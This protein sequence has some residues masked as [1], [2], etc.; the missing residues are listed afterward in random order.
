[1]KLGICYSFFFFDIK[2][3]TLPLKLVKKINNKIMHEVASRREKSGDPQ[4]G[5]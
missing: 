5:H 2:F 3:V 4:G 1:M